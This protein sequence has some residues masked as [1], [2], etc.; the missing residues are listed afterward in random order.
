MV[1]ASHFGG[2]GSLTNRRIAC[3]GLL[4]IVPSPQE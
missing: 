3:F 4:K 2:L 1:M